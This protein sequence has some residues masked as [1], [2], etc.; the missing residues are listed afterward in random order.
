MYQLIIETPSRLH[1]TLLDL[2]GIYG[3]IDGGVGITLKNPC[4]K[5]EAE[6]AHN[7]I[8]V[9]FSKSSQL[10]S[11]YVHD[12]TIKIENSAIKIKNKLEIE[13]GFKF[14]VETA[15]PPHSGLGSGTQLSLA[16]AKLISTMNDQDLTALDLAKIV[17][18]R[19]TKKV[20][21]LKVVEQ[22]NN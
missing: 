19:K 6:S 7:G 5:L 12:Y 9:G 17:G 16:V 14:T 2:N 18:R 13:G 11:D 22:I 8:E 15:F 20:D 21:K 3:R 4:L 10:I 1:L